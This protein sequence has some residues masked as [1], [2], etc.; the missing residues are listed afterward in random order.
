MGREGQGGGQDYIP[1]YAELAQMIQADRVEDV[2]GDRAEAN[3]NPVR[4]WNGATTS[5]QA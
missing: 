1:L 3:I 2:K 5:S 4:R